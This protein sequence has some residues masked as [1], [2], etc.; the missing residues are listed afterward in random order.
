ME[1]IK[2]Y[3]IHVGDAT[4]QWVNVVFLLSQNPNESISG[5]SWRL[6]KN[7]TGWG[8]AKKAIDF[9]LSWMEDDHCYKAYQ[10]DLERARR[11]V[12]LND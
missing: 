9:L 5:R 1:S 8:Y 7:H 11:L 2:S 10:A 12:E 6:R 3:L 4:S